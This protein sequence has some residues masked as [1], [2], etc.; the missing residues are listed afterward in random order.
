[1]KSGWAKTHSLKEFNMIISEKQQEANRRNAQLSSGPKTAEGKAAVRFN[2]LTYGLRTRSLLIPTEDHAGSA[3]LWADLQADWQPQ[4][5]TE[6]LYLE[7]MF[8]SHWLLAR[9]ATSEDRIYREETQLDNQ[10]ALLNRVS[11]LR[12]RLERSFTCARREL[13]QMQKERTKKERQAPQPRP[14]P[15]PVRKPAAPQATPPPPPYVMSEAAEPHPVS[16]SALTPD[17]R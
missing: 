5:R 11:M 2:A 4:S 8:A 13:E 7:Q 9:L 15:A 10:L 14:A 1:M 6:Y 16:C 17:S 3:E 12:T